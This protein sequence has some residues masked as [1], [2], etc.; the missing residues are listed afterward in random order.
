MKNILRSITTKVVHLP[1]KPVSL[2]MATLITFNTTLIALFIQ[3]AYYN[4]RLHEVA[5]GGVS[6]TS[7]TESTTTNEANEELISEVVPENGADLEIKW[8]DLGKRL[9]ETGVIDKDKMMELF[10]GP[11]SSQEYEEILDGSVDKN[12][13]VTADNSRFILNTLWAAGLAQQS[14]ALEETQAQYSKDVANLASTGGWTIGKGSSMDHYGKHQLV[15]LTSEQQDKVKEIASNIYR[16]CCNNHSAFPDCNHGMAML[17]LIELMVAEGKSDE[18]IYKT[19]LKVNS[20]WF[21]NTYLT[22]ASYMKEKKNTEWK[23][24]NAKEVLGGEY[25]SGS[26]YKAILAQVQPVQSG[27]SGGGCGV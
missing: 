23:D 17:G 24:V 3:G 27:N 5:T 9:V 16:P 18:E 13:V 6:L 7:S 14:K 22:L 10:N 15:N 11:L 8:N 2:F 21:S 26:G 4:A 19:A 25:S 12:I 1:Q 20:L